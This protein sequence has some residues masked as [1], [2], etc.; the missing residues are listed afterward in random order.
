MTI[1]KILQEYRGNLL[2]IDEAYLPGAGQYKFNAIERLNRETAKELE[3]LLESAVPEK[4]EIKLAKLYAD[5]T[6]H[7]ITGWNTC[8]DTMLN[9]LKG[10]KE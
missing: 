5:K 7:E 10:K 6:I 1:S 8:R 4:K 2:K 9:N 3:A